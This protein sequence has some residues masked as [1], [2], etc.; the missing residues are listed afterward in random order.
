MLMATYQEEG[1]LG[2]TTGGFPHANTVEEVLALLKKK[3]IT[4]IEIVQ[5][6]VGNVVW[7]LLTANYEVDGGAVIGFF[8]NLRTVEDVLAHLEKRGISPT[9]I[10]QGRPDNVVWP[11]PRECT[12]C[13]EPFK[14]GA[15]GCATCC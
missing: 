1:A 9:T 8:P 7:E 13:G 6:K 11:R 15:I 3:G 14:E 12:R 5:D 10:A 4:P 2:F